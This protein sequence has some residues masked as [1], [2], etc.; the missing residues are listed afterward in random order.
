MFSCV[1]KYPFTTR[2]LIASWYTIVGLSLAP[3]VEITA[4]FLAQPSQSGAHPHLPKSS[5]RSAIIRL[6]LWVCTFYKAFKTY[7]QTAPQKSIYILI[8]GTE[9]YPL[10]L[11]SCRTGQCSFDS[12]PSKDKKEVR[13]ISRNV[14]NSVLLWDPVDSWDLTQTAAKV[15]VRTEIGLR[16]KLKL[17]C[18]TLFWGFR[19]VSRSL[20]CQSNIPQLKKNQ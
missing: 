16:R 4:R 6:N 10:L 13:F 1:S 8:G 7:C 3:S 20:K 11:Q 18:T 17:F 12:W 5:D 19:C 2:V 15:K 14:I 9:A